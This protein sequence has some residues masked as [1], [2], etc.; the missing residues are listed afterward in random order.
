MSNTLSIKVG[1]FLF[2]NQESI[3]IL[4]DDAYASTFLLFNSFDDF[5]TLCPT[6]REL[7]SN[8]LEIDVFEDGANV[9]NDGTY[10]LL[11]IDKIQVIG[12]SNLLKNERN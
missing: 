5:I 8:I 6:E 12:Y 1:K 9:K 3:I 10:E 4:A 11:S 7:I 2:D